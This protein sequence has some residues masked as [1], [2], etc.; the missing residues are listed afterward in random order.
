V[1]NFGFLLPEW[2][3][4]HE[5]AVKA[6]DAAHGDPRTSAFHARRAL[7]LTVRWAYKADAALKLPYQDNVSALL[8]E[9]TFKQVAG[10]AVFNKC[11]LIVSVGNRAAHDARNIPEAAAL[12]AV[13]ELFHVCYWLA[14]T[15]ARGSRPDPQL[16]FD[17]SQLPLDTSAILQSISILQALES[18]LAERDER[19]V[20][21]LADRNALDDEVKTLRAGVAKA[22]IVNEQQEDTHDYDEAKTRAHLIDALLHEAGWPLDQGRDREFEVSGMPNGSGQGFVDYVFWGDDGKPIGLVE[23]KRTTV[24]PKLGK[25]QAK[26]YADCLEIAFDQRPVIFYTNGYQHWM[27]DDQRDPPRSVYGFYTKDELGLAIQRRNS[28]KSLIGAQFDTRI[29]ERYYQVRAIRRI[30]ESFETDNE[31]K[32]LLVMA[33]G[34]GKTRTVIALVDLLARCNWAKRVLFLADRVALVNQAVGAFKT[35]LPSSSAVNLVTEKNDEGRVYVST[36][37]TMMGLINDISDGKRRFGVGHFDLVVIDEAHRSIYQKYRAIFDY[38][39]SFLVGLTATPKDEVDINTYGLFDLERGV[40]TD[41]YDLDQAVADGFLVPP[42][43]IDVPLKF[44]RQGIK[45]AALSDDEKERWDATEWDDNGNIPTEIG[46]S[47]LNAWLFNEDTVDKVLANL[48]DQGIKVKGGDRL[49]KTIIFAKS[50]AHAEFIVERFDANYPQLKGAFAR[51]IHHG[52]KYA[53]SLIDDFSNT[54]KMPHIAVSVDMLDTGIDVPDVVNLVFFKPVYSRS[55]FWQMIGRGTRLRPDLF[56]P[57]QHKS[58]F[59]VFDYCGNFDFFAQDLPAAEGRLVDSLGKRL[60]LTRLELVATLDEGAKR[61]GNSSTLEVRDEPT[62]GAA[63]LRDHTAAAL[64]AE[65]AAMNVDN[66]LVRPKRQLVDK[67]AK[68]D[69]W[70]TL[71]KNDLHAL[72]SD[73]AGLPSELDS[74]DEEAKRFDLLMYRLQLTMLRREPAYDRLRKN[75]IEIAA[76]LEDQANIPMVRERLHVIADLQSEDWWQDVTVAMVDDIRKKLRS[77]VRLIEKSKRKLIYTDFEDELGAAIEV[78]LIGVLPSLPMEAF[79][80]KAR[81]FLRAYEDEIAIHRVRMNKQLTATDLASLER[82]LGGSGIG[83]AELLAK[84]AQ[85][86][87]GLGLFVRGLVGMDREAAKEAFAGFLASRTMTASQIEFVDL[88]IEHLTNQGVVA[89][90]RFYESPFTD[91]APTGPQGIFSGEEVEEL[92]GILERVRAA[93]VA[94]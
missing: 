13:E 15:Y 66:F 65:V 71:G 58:C 4:I 88:I 80:D 44:Q 5:A 8:H 51:S 28:R 87:Q 86:A 79:R 42:L 27:W 68:V 82:V 93:A 73:V 72:A 23:A 14:H 6:E 16:A 69:A 9:S 50:Q 78:D 12:A 75:V 60:F 49:G 57:D 85:D 62:S 76:L 22:K 3:Q 77:L 7:E 45:Y 1:S 59:Y 36:Y 18:S 46:A 37:P 81:A 55:K 25:Q 2:P 52:V 11:R 54:E 40:P 74:E 89:A 35:H 83:D 61:R 21:L 34:A 84:A 26:L 94:A 63:A 90:A 30:S 39:D 92:V 53:H 47:A 43:G 64:H 67:F 38:F 33:T 32:A 10:E 20:V 41:Y 29:V 19:L 48:M 31:R 24:D 17:S 56:G 91:I 70:S